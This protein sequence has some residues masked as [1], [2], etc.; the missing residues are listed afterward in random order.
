MASTYSTNLGIE[1][2]ANGEQAGTWG[3]TTNTNLGT[4]IE[5][6]I[7]GYTT[8]TIT[9]G[10]D[11]T[12]TIPNG[13]SGT[14]RN[15]YLQLS[16]ALTAS[17][18][19]IVPANKKLYFIYN[20]TSGGFAVTV[21]VSGQTGVSVPNG[22]KMALVSNGTDIVEAVTHFNTFTA[23]SLNATPVGNTTASTGAFTTLSA[24]ST[25]SGTGFT[26][27]FASP[28]AL[29]G[30]AANTVTATRV[31]VNGSTVPANGIYLPSA[32]EL[33][34]ATNTTNRLTVK[35]GLVMAG[36]TGGTAGDMG[37]GTI[38][39]TG[40]YINGVAVG[41]GSGSVSSVALS[42]GSTGL[43]VTGSPI[44]TSGTFTLGGTVAVASGGTGQSTYTNG[45]L[46]I[47]NTTG[48][49]LTKATLTAGSGISITN[50]AGSI[51]IASTAGG[52]TVTNVTANSPLS[53]TNGSTTPD[54]TL[55]TVTAGKGGTGRTTLTANSLLA[56]NGTGI[57]NL[58]AA[59]ADG[60]V[61]TASGGAWVSAA[62]GASGVSSISFASTG[63]TPST[64]STGAITVAGT[65]GGGYGGTGNNSYAVGDILYAS[66]SASLSKLAGVATGNALISGGVTTAPAWGKIGLTT[67]VSGQLGVA[68]GGTGVATL[69][70]IVKASGTSAFTAAV[71]GTDYL[72]PSGSGANLTSL[73]ASNISSGTLATARLPAAAL[74]NVSTGYNSGGQV[75]VS[76]TQPTAGAAG[77]IWIDIS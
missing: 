31:I 36:A 61:L 77:D 3:T 46:L 19:L 70:G 37:S 17:R 5:E 63:L 38:N 54:I 64:A 14:A 29:G 18:N 62:P 7:S 44:S 74:R 25:V 48:S 33:G 20:N 45:Q 24:S 12:I 11:T 71:A 49:T 30:T 28:P 53:V 67:H 4:L 1:L 42:G 75:F 43:T 50:G 35:A 21:K 23:G 55:G 69:T 6:A 60:Q 26:N 47:G 10:A 72:T 40:V 41:T 68:N 56:G 66:G 22:A 16:G 51:T 39:A 58:I 32:N 52:G 8:V 73:N 13:A 2:I 27:Y 15:M 9:D 65:L 76:T 57:V 59:G 34:V